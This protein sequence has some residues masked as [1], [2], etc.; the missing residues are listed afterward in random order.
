MKSLPK[1][2]RDLP[3]SSGWE[4]DSGSRIPLVAPNLHPG[5]RLGYSL[6]FSTGSNLCSG[7]GRC[8]ESDPPNQYPKKLSRIPIPKE[9]SGA[10]YSEGKIQ[11]R[12]FRRKNPVQIIPKEKSSAYVIPACR[13]MGTHT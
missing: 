5:N 1:G 2:E 13:E 7:E 3:V 4:P 9:K 10:D 8:L 12:L 11:C 6:N